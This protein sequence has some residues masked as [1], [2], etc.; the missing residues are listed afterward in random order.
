MDFQTIIDLDKQLLLFF[1]GSESLFL[2]A[3]VTTLTNAWTWVPLYISLL[4][5]VIKNSDSVLGVFLVLASA[6]L[7]VLFT[8]T[9]DDTIVKPLVGR[10]RPTRDP[11]IGLLVDIVDGYRGGNYGFFS[12][13]ASNT[14]SIAIF[15][16]LLV[17]SRVFTIF[18]MAWSLL[19]AWTRLYLGVHYPSDVIVGLAY[20][21]FVGIMVYLIFMKLYMIVTDKLHFISSQYTRTGYGF[22]DIDIVHNVLLLTIVY[23]VIHA[24]VSAF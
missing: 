2:D 16:S 21:A 22:S 14:F 12:A 11:E 6:A 15:F 20:G 17:R 4:I 18:I 19:N 8:G 7:C 5:V 10:W 1:N 9:L 23:A 3:M 13:H 24:A